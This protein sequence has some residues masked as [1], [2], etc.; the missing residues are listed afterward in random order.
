MKCRSCWQQNEDSDGCQAPFF[1]I[2]GILSER[3]V[4]IRFWP[5]EV[6]ILGPVLQVVFVSFQGAVFLHFSSIHALILSK[7]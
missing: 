3:N 7:D 4:V 1:S 2:R 5:L 6:D